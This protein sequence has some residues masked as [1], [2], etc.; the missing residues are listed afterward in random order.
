[1]TTI[2]ACVSAKEGTGKTTLA[3]ALAVHWSRCGQRVLLVD[4]DPRTTLT[5]LFSL[6][7]DKGEIELM[8]IRSPRS[9]TEL[10]RRLPG[11]ESGIVIVDTAPSP[12][13]FGS[14][15]RIA[16]VL[17]IPTRPRSSDLFDFERTLVFC[18][19]FGVPIVI[20]PN[21]VKSRSQRN[22]AGPALTAV[23]DGRAAIAE[24]IGELADLTARS[25]QGMSIVDIDPPATGAAEIAG[26]AQAVNN[27]AQSRI[28][29]ANSVEPAAQGTS[30]RRS[31][32]KRRLKV[33]DTSQVCFR[34]PK[35]KHQA[36]KL[37]CLENGLEIGEAMEKALDWLLSDQ[38]R[39]RHVIQSAR[40]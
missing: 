7:A 39:R 38:R 37:Y 30:P 27:A 36:L 31:R 19:P 35:H 12:N 6:R 33:G 32:S 13:D 16:D 28:P 5:K 23:C 21:R 14:V 4:C 24:P 29:S 1:M 3:L 17:V 18:E 40:V 10:R 9:E 11:D 15:V 20:A 26:L 22:S 8:A 34:V 25:L 2:V